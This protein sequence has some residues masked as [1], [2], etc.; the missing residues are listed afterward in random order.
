MKIIGIEHSCDETYSVR[1]K[2]KRQNDKTNRAGFLLFLRI[3]G[4][5]QCCR[6]K[7]QRYGNYKQEDLDLQ[8]VI[9]RASKAGIDKQYAIDCREEQYDK[10]FAY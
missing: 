8:Y 9:D 1:Q 7:Q 10:V 5:Q 2:Y 6:V 3:Y 4:N